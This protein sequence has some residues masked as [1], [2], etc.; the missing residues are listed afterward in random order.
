[1]MT[2]PNSFL[3][4]VNYTMRFEVGTFWNANNTDVQDGTNLKNCGYSIDPNDPGGETKYGLSKT[5]N[6]D[7]NIKSLNWATAQYI[8]YNRYW[9]PSKCDYMPG[10]IG[11]LMFDSAVNVGITEAA[12]FLQR[13]LSVVDDGNIGPITLAAVNTVDP[14]V[15]CNSICDQRIHYYNLIV[16]HRPSQNEYLKGW[17]NRV[18]DIR[19]FV[20]NLNNF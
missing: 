1:M 7:I 9:V 15:L 6:P 20:T 4:A 14:I 5:A 16:A 12:K 11:A 10:R 8:Y 3:L 2:Y 18:S 19:V 17:L 13:S